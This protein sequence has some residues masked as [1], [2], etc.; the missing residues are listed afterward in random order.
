MA[1][2]GQGTISIEWCLV[3]LTFNLV[4]LRL[5]A[6]L[7]IQRDRVNFGDIL[8]VL[9][10]LSL[11]SMAACDTWL[12]KLGLMIPERT[13]N[14]DL[15]H[16]TEDP[17]KN[18]LILKIIYG[19]VLPYYTALWLVKCA[20]L[21]FYYT[22]I[23]P[24]LTAHRKALHFVTAAVLISMFGVLSINIFWC[25]PVSLNWSLNKEDIC[26]SFATIPV[27][28][29]S[30]ACNILTDI[31]IFILP[32]PLLRNI[33]F[34]RRSQLVGLV[35]I[36]TLGCFSMLASVVR[37]AVLADTATQTHIAV[38]SAVEVAIGI[39][40]ASLPSLRILI[41]KN[42]GLISVSSSSGS[43]GQAES[44]VICTDSSRPGGA[45]DWI[46]LEEKAE[47]DTLRSKNRDT[48]KS[49][50]TVITVPTVEELE[51]IVSDNEATPTIR[52][53]HDLQR[54]H[55]TMLNKG[56]ND[57]PTRP[58]HEWTFDKVQWRYSE[59]EPVTP[60]IDVHGLGVIP[61][62]PPIPPIP[63]LPIRTVHTSRRSR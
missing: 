17:E 23:P 19:S 40:I 31:A 57:A 7:L 34:Q 22:I 9:A 52:S 51:E 11:S 30:T 50:T 39:I 38:W 33:K 13:Y 4:A 45:F 3:V 49:Q 28:I 8:L 61:D 42:G 27:F 32:F 63:P 10:W 54:Y 26:F 60:V 5:V 59:P 62:V 16:I 41:W 6:R 29:I 24:S 58:G 14:H 35:T 44:G 25:M 21:S 37:V 12:L 55:D 48:I 36:F 53:I 1:L 18:V 56:F 47:F 20:L 43:R 2:T 15:A 46:S